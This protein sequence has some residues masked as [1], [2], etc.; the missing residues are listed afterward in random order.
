MRAICKTKGPHV[1]APHNL[2]PKLLLRMRRE[3]RPA[4]LACMDQSQVLRQV[5]SRFG[6]NALATSCLHDPHY[7]VR[8]IF[9]RAWLPARTASDCHR[10]ARTV[11]VPDRYNS[12]T[13]A[14]RSG[15][16]LRRPHEE[17]QTVLAPR[18]WSSSLLAAQGNARD[19]ASRKAND[20][21]TPLT[22]DIH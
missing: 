9:L 18:P 8:R 20:S 16:Y 1:A 5:L 14:L 7:F 13:H 4:A 21:V 11:V 10:A 19:A 3:D 17:R 12:T 15:V 6:E 22:D 2:P